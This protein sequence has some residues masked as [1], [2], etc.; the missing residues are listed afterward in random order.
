MKKLFIPAILLLFISCQEQQMEQSARNITVEEVKSY[1]ENNF[2]SNAGRVDHSQII[3]DQA[4]YRDISLGDALVFPIDDDRHVVFDDSTSVF[5]HLPAKLTS[6]AFAYK[7]DE[8][9]NIEYVKLIPYRKSEGYTGAVIVENFEGKQLRYFEYEN[10]EFLSEFEIVEDHDERGRTSEFVYSC[11]TTIYYTCADYP[12]DCRETD[13]ST[14]CVVKEVR[15]IGGPGTNGEDYGGGG[16]GGNSNMCPHPFLIGEF[17]PCSDAPCENGYIKDNDGNC[18]CPSTMEVINSQCTPKC[19]NGYRRNE[20][21]TNCVQIENC[22]TNDQI[23]SAL[24]GIFEELWASSNAWH[25]TIPMNQR[26]E[27]GGWIV[28]GTPGGYSY[29]PFPE[30][31]VFTPCGI[32]AVIN[33]S[34]IPANV[35]GLVHTHPFYVGEDRRSVCQTSETQY[36]GAPSSEDYYTLVAIMNMLGNFNLKGYVIDGNKVSSYNFTGASSLVQINRCGY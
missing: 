29:V 13:R 26:R 10:G 30:S 14:T 11:T 23:I 33:P 25:T 20:N 24:E 19:P 17:V 32:D 21:G 7:I 2:S 3:W 16:N 31:W 1:Y 9:I 6:Y 34:D 36:T 22:V 5:E 27:G 4:L 8:E 28:S 12:T 15:M 18:F 35:V